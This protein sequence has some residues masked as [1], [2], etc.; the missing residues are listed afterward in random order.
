MNSTEAELL[1]KPMYVYI[2]A[3]MWWT[4]EEW[5]MTTEEREKVGIK[6]IKI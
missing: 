2:K 3:P 4:P 6:L 1:T 5:R